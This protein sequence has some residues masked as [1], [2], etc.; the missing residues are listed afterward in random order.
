MPLIF[1]NLIIIHPAASTALVRKIANSI[2]SSARAFHN[3]TSTGSF[4]VEGGP[5]DEVIS[6]CGYTRPCI[7]KMA[8][9]LDALF[10]C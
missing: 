6:I 9:V 3:A 5:G 8:P 7:A 2:G 10:H 1:T 4:C